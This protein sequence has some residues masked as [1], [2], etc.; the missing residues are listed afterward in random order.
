MCKCNIACG[1][2]DL[3]N[4]SK[5]MLSE[6]YADNR[7]L[8]MELKKELNLNSQKQKLAT[9]STSSLFKQL[10]KDA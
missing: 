10:H 5:E 2:E 8:M 3:S 6:L 7:K 1:V 9:N 4:D